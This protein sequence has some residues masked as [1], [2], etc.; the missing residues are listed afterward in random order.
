[1]YNHRSMEENI[2]EK[3]LNDLPVGAESVG[4]QAD[5]MILCAKCQRAIPP[6]KPNCFYC[7]AELEISEAQR[8]FLRPNLRKL[9]AWEK[10]YNLII[11]PSAPLLDSSKIAE[12]GRTLKM[13]TETLRKII[14]AGKPLPIVRAE[15]EKE[16]A[17]AQNCLHHSDLESFIV[18][19]ENLHLEKPPRRLRGIEF[20]DDSL[21][22]ILFNQDEIVEIKREDLAL[23][24]TGAIYERRIEATEK[25]SKK[26]ENKMLDSTETASDE[27]LIDI[28]SCEDLIGWRMLAKGF[29]FSCLEAEKGILAKDN[30][31][32]LADKLQNFASN[33]EF[34][35][36]YRRLRE[37]LGTIWE[38]S[39]TTA[40]QG[41]KRDGIGKFNLENLTTVNNLSQFTRYSR[42]QR[43]LL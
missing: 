16:A 12:I 41:L 29:D 14:E 28:Y 6:T 21:I 42:L 20:F 22:L 3:W 17:I 1:M 5:E 8:R 11:K 38:V 27:S 2:P 19:D 36:D 33:A 37:Y 18:S 10:G 13:E 40:S 23:I 32:K 4:F 43:N 9:E 26:G 30:I 31:V 7:G 25:H 35:D 34:V 39:Q 15:S 24:V